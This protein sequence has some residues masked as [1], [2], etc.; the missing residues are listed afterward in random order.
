MCGAG[1]RGACSVSVWM[2][3]LRSSRNAMSSYPVL[4]IPP[5][6]SARARTSPGAPSGSSQVL[7]EDHAGDGFPSGDCTT[8]GQLWAG[9]EKP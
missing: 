9:G 4:P 2:V 8:A 1:F 7:S 3:S 5:G 6:T